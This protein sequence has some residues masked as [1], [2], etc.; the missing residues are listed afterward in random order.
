MVKK[1][2]NKTFLA[3]EA[4]LIGI[5]TFLERLMPILTPSGIILGL[6]LGSRISHLKGATLW[7]FAF[8]S[9][10]G[11]FGVHLPD[12]VS[13]IKKPTPVLLF[14]AHSYLLFPSLVWASMQVFFP[15]QG[16]TMLGFYLLCSVPTAVVGYVWSSIYKGDPALSLILLLI[17]TIAAPLATPLMMQILSRSAVA[18]D[19]S[20]MVISLVQM[21]LI[22][23]LLGMTITRV[24]HNRV[25]EYV[26]PSLKPFT[27]VAIFTLMAINASQLSD[28]FFN[29]ISVQLIPIAIGCILFTFVGFAL[30][31]GFAAL[32]RLK[33]AQAT[34]LMF[35]SGLRNINAAL[36][37]AVEFFAAPV[38][39]PVMIGIFF[40]QLMSAV[41]A[42]I[43]LGTRRSGRGE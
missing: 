4:A 33:R 32:V 25:N 29:I 38:A 30:A 6:I 15:N 5:N 13:I 43:L 7:L 34:S 14:L 2:G 24:T 12:F 36:V 9:L 26:T 27:K 10:V 11:G 40:Q 20:G 16:D 21:V 42:T 41:S 35:A 3:I 1:T 37:L 17:G 22:P 23:S 19:V 28:A 8:I 39:I 18:F 31:R